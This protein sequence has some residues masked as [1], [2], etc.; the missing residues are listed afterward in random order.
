[1]TAGPVLTEQ[2]DLLSKY[3]WDIFLIGLVLSCGPVRQLLPRFT[4]QMGKLRSRGMSHYLSCLQVARLEYFGYIYSL[5]PS[6]SLPPSDP[7][8]RKLAIV[9]SVLTKLP[10]SG[11]PSGR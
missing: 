1:M 2:L 6:Y 9:W 4:M 11:G 3:P 7:S 5:L 10:S 8:P